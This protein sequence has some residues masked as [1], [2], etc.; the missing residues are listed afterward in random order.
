M[1]PASSEFKRI[2]NKI[3][4]RGKQTNPRDLKVKEI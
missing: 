3:K 1:R 2:L 4:N